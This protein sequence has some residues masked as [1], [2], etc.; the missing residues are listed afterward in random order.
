MNKVWQTISAREQR[1]LL[2]LLPVAALLLFLVLVRPV[3]S[4][5]SE[6]Q[7][8]LDL[9]LEDI[10]WFQVQSPRLMQDHCPL[11]GA[12]AEGYDVAS[13]A[14]QHGVQL[15]ADRMASAAAELDISAANGNQLLG[16]LRALECRGSNVLALDIETLDAAGQVR[17]RVQLSAPVTNLSR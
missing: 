8:R 6:A 4:G 3:W 11:Q 5:A 7:A 14:R 15:G 13:L 10:A 16:F 17:G 1:L 12:G 2:Q 9:A